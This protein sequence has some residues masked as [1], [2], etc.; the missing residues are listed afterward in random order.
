MASKAG[1]QRE[2]V[3]TNMERNGWDAPTKWFAWAVLLAFTALSAYMN[4]AYAALSGSVVWFHAGIP[5]VVLVLGVFLELTYLSSAHRAAKRIVIT[6]LAACFGTVLVASYLAVLSVTTAWNGAAPAWV[7]AALAGIPDVVM[8]LA[9][10]MILSLRLRTHA[11]AAKAPK[12]ATESRFKRLADAATARAESALAVPPSPQVTAVTD[13]RGRSTE[14]LTQPH[15][16]SVEATAE[17]STDDPAGVRGA[18]TSTVADAPVESTK[19][20]ASTPRTPRR[21][22]AKPSVD[23]ELVPFM[24]QAERMVADGIVARKTPQEIAAVIR[25]IDEGATDNAIKKA[26]IASAGTAQKVR[27]ELEY[28][29]AAAP[30]AAVG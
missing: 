3:V 24:E 14:V 22:T 2:K 18:S 20:T 13:V 21:T 5:G 30:L 7:N 15:G 23:P 17:V 16:A 28:Q 1:S 25:A 9:A 4:A 12:K 29:R 11:T 6:G 8:V 27:A 10:T 26:G 19:A